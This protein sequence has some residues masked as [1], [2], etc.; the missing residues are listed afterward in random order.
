ML[1]VAPKTI[2]TTQL[3]Q[4]HANHPICADPGATDDQG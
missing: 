4:D 3:F 2:E 1:P